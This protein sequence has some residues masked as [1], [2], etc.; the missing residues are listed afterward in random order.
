MSNMQ[1]FH[2]RLFQTGVY[3]PQ[4]QGL[5]QLTE[6]NSTQ[7]KALESDEGWNDWDS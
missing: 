2:N 3:D 5:L 4:L 6:A 1:V 7:V